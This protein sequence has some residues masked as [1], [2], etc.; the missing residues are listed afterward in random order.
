MKRQQTA[1]AIFSKKKSNTGGITIPNFKLY[2]KA[3]A[4]K[5][6]WYRHKNRHEARL[7]R[8]RRP[9]IV[10]SPSYM[11]FRSRA[12]TAMLLD[13]GHMIRGDYIWEVW[14]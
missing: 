2:C 11:D 5:T 12:N 8:L 3:I 9:K 4:I 14:R 13:L 10:C 1:K 7:A 6:A